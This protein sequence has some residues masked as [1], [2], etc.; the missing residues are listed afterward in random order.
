MQ[1][2]AGQTEWGECMK[3]L[4]DVMKD[5]KGAEYELDSVMEPTEGQY[6]EST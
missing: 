4:R 1:K 6:P 3:N 2:K 5:S